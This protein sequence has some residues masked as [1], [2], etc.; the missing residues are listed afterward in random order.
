MTEGDGLCSRGAVN[1]FI[2]IQGTTAGEEAFRRT[3]VSVSSCKDHS[4]T[5]KSV[6]NDHLYNDIYYL[7]FIQ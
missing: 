3:M 6:C 5:V 4:D 2:V 1:L 7:W